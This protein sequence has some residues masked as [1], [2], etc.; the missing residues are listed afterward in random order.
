MGDGRVALILDVL[1][2][3]QR[4]GVV[5]Q[6]RDRTL[7]DHISR[8]ADQRTRQQSLLL[9]ELGDRRLALPIAMVSRL[10]EIPP[11]SIEKADG[12]EVVQYRGQ[13]LRLLRLSEWLGVPSK[14]AAEEPLQVVVHTDGDR[15]IGLV[16]DRIADI[17]DAA[18]DEVRAGQSNDIRASAI[19]Q[20]R[21]TD[22]ID[23][24]S[25]VRRAEPAFFRASPEQEP[26][27][28]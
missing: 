13:I 16:V 17:V 24:P 25:L 23:L 18:V 1:G 6:V 22:L 28:A 26:I 9:L 10:E 3:A 27:L 2:T 8:S 21:V 5:A 4:S 19:I 14:A 11:A 12:R 20:Q 15:S 7:S